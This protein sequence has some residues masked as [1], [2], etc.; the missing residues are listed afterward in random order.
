MSD[1]RRSPGALA[2]LGD[3][4]LDVVARH[5]RP[6]AIGSDTPAL[7]DSRPGGAGAN[8]AAWAGVAGADVTFHGCV[9]D[10]A[11]GRTA[12]EAL[13][14]CGVRTAVQTAR[15]GTPTGTCVVLVDAS[16]ERSMLPGHGA[17]DV[18]EPVRLHPDTALLHLS[19]YT[20]LHPGSREAGLATLAMALAAG[21]AV[22]VDPASAAL[23]ADAGAE[24]L[25]AALAGA[26]MMILNRDE[27][28]VLTGSADAAGI[29]EALHARG[30]VDVVVKLGAEGAVW[31]RAS[32]AAIAVP[33]A[34]P[35]GPVVD[36]TGAGDAFAGT[37]LAGLVRG[38]E[39]REALHAAVRFAAMVCTREGA[40]PVTA[41]DPP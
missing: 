19:G 40:W 39:R 11:F 13:R 29:A 37:L 41:A 24:W 21:V 20:V 14:T 1:P 12:L 8:C 18:L 32:E 10:D 17:N 2:V 33:A 3:V 5:Q 31:S 4:M 36:T 34:A 35:P 7:I 25:L 26:E 38:A 6:L 22:S 28:A 9:G 30:F 15:D 16:A 23:I 27:G